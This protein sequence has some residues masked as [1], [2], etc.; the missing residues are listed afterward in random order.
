MNNPSV[1]LKHGDMV[2]ELSTRLVFQIVG[3]NEARRTAACRRFGPRGG[4]KLK[5]I[6]LAGLTRASPRRP[7]VPVFS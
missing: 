5:T 2:T 4:E 3:I 6:A 1:E 7:I